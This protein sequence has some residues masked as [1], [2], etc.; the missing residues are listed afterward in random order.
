MENNSEKDLRVS[1]IIMWIL[2]IINIYLS[3]SWVFGLISLSDASL[4][5]SMS[6]GISFATWII[7]LS[8]IIKSNIYNKKWWLVM[9]ICTPLIAE[10][11]YL[12]Q[13][14]KLINLQK[15]RGNFKS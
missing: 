14:E 4:F 10:P 2:V 13:R 1:P 11:I 12:I 9:M 5:L 8:D 7:F 15:R 3:F 6:F